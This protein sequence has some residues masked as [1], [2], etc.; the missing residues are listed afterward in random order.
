MSAKH[1]ITGFLS[2]IVIAIVS[3]F[4]IYLFIPEFS[5]KYL[6]TS[7]KSDRYAKKTVLEKSEDL[8]KE[9]S[10]E[11]SKTLDTVSDRLGDFFGK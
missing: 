2:A 10:K 1:K 5:E 9:V 8:I 3:F 4:V 7:L 11:S 6:G